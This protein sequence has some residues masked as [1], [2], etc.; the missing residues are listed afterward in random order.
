MLHESARAEL[1][2]EVERLSTENADVLERL[3]HLT[4]S[5]A[6]SPTCASVMQE[7][8]SPELFG[9][10]RA[11]DCITAAEGTCRALREILSHT[12]SRSTGGTAVAQ[13]HTKELE[14]LLRQREEFVRAQRVTVTSLLAKLSPSS[15][16]SLLDTSPLASLSREVSQCWKPSTAPTGEVS[17]RVSQDGLEKLG[18]E[19]SLR[20]ALLQRQAQ[21]T[22]QSQCCTLRDLQQRL[23]PTSASTGLL[24]STSNA[25]PSTPAQELVPSAPPAEVA[26]PKP[27]C[28]VSQGPSATSGPV[29]FTQGIVEELLPGATQRVLRLNAPQQGSLLG[30]SDVGWS[31]PSLAPKLSPPRLANSTAGPCVGGSVGEIPT[32]IGIGHS[33]GERSPLCDAMLESAS[34]SEW[35]GFE[36]R[37]R[38]TNTEVRVE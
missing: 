29:L 6:T 21:A 7:A 13:N 24:S 35:D 36:G 18:S 33:R 16:R 25:G 28:D 31:F 2:R 1:Q 11:K 4:A 10:V 12:Q 15:S 23:Q 27:Y 8:W 14:L 9:L 22:S 38:Q 30:I 3:T 5:R 34:H 20:V 19:V 32:V 37:A 26:L 17:T